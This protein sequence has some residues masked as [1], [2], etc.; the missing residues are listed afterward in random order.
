MRKRNRKVF[1]NDKDKRE[2]S[3]LIDICHVNIKNSDDVY[4]YLTEERGL[5]DSIIKEYKIGFF[6]QNTNKL[7]QYVSRL[8]LEELSILDYSGNSE[9]SDFFYL[10]FP[11]YSEY[12][13]P[14]GIGGRTLMSTQQREIAAI[15][16]YK[17]S[18]FSKADILFGLSA[19][20][21]HILKKQNVYVTEGY[22]DQISMRQ[23]NIKNSVAICGT[24]FSKKHFI[25]LARYTKKITFVLDRDE[26]GRKSMESINKKFNNR[27]ISL[28]FKLLPE[29]YKDVDE[30]FAAGHNKN[31][32]LESLEDFYP[33]LEEIGW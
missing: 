27:G 18:S 25:R 29:G 32:F 6:P 22:F 19:S 17:N 28:G 2:L 21:G 23:N 10:I 26:G 1:L 16:K 3:K 11:I 14:V 5:S 31:E 15:P 33:G 20:R 4:T 9:F 13:E 30:F 24:A 7:S 8:T 12:M